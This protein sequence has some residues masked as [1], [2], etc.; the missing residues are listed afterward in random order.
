MHGVNVSVG[1]DPGFR[2]PVR[3][4]WARQPARQVRDDPGHDQGDVCWIL[5]PPP[6]RSR[7]SDSPVL[8]WYRLASSQHHARPDSADPANV[9]MVD[10]AGATT[11]LHRTLLAWDYFDLCDK[12]DETGGIFDK[13]ELIPDTFP[14]I[15]VSTLVFWVAV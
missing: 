4:F 7:L 1:Q 2:C 6:D 12:S 8:V 10:V 13:L 14:S 9:G 5:R 11:A 3:R 15:E